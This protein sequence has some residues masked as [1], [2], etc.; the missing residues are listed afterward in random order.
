MDPV[1]SP[2]REAIEEMPTTLPLR[3]ATITRP[4]AVAQK[5]AARRFRFTTVSQSAAVNSTAGRRTVVPALL[6]RMS[7]RPRSATARSIRPGIPSRCWR[8]IGWTTARRPTPSIDAATCWSAALSRLA[9]TTSQPAAARARAAAAPM[10][11]LAPVTM[12]T[13]PRRSG[14]APAMRP[15]LPARAPGRQTPG[16]D[17][18]LRGLAPDEDADRFLRHPALEVGAALLRVPGGVR[19]DDDLLHPD[20]RARR[21][22]WLLLGHVEAGAGQPAPLERRD[23]RRG[24]HEAAARGVDEHRGRLHAGQ[25]RAVDQVPG[26]GGQRAVQ[27]H[28][29]RLGEQALQPGGLDAGRERLD[30][31]VVAE[32]PDVEPAELPGDAAAD[33]PAAD[34]PHGLAGQAVDR[35]GLEDVPAPGA[36]LAVEARDLPDEGEQEGDGVVRTLVRPVVGDVGDRGAALGGGVP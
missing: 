34:D 6:I 22:E 31:G 8:S 17:A 32:E 25:C 2:T 15:R 16:I 19:G 33:P 18:V 13:L 35:L 20:E 29:V 27:R 9:S 21:V 23:Q 24:V 7:S 4:A 3:W 26:G 28:V 14:V 5:K 10:P 30:V 36:R 11:R 12:A 1:G